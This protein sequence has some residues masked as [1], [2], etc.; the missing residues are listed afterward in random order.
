MTTATITNAELLRRREAAV[1]RGMFF[2]APV[3]AERAENARIW[4][5][6]GKEYIDFC[7]GI[8]VVNVGHNHPKVVEAVKA[9]ADR[10]LHTGFNVVMYEEYV[11]LAE[12]LNEL[13]PIN[14]PCK[15]VFF[16]SGAEAGEN[17][18]KICRFYT[19]RS[20]VVAF[21]R[22]F[23]GRT[24][25]GMTLTGKCKP[26]SAGFGPFA[27]EVYRLPYE[28]FFALP[29]YKSDAEV[30]A[31]CNAALDHLFSYHCEAE[32]V[33]CVLVEPVLGEGGFLPLHCVAMRILRDRCAEN[34]ILFV[35]DEVQ[36]GFGRCGALFACQRYEIEPDMVAM[37]KSLAGGLVLSGVTARKEIMDAP[38]VGGIG[39]TYGGNPVACAAAN[40]VLD[41]MAEEN[42]PARALKIGEKTMAVLEDLEKTY[43]FFANAR[44]LGAMCAIEVVDPNSGRPDL[45]RVARLIA[46]A[47]DNGL[48]LMTASGNVVRTLMPLTIPDADLEKAFGILRR[49]AAS[50]A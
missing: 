20:G 14:G 41:I 35:S 36:S 32:N 50:V 47:R 44:G 31:E 27:P 3:F 4:D 2:V 30:E 25:L 9:Q 33:A 29:R 21:E 8:G 49:S 22:G 40:A 26:Y 23:H 6:E 46:T 48:L 16:N 5:V 10:F 34:G 42:L 19:K 7:G 24:L 1:P 45:D 17:A 15:T 43:P 28:P 18:V 37:A 13:V 12:R 11:R 38:G 39:G